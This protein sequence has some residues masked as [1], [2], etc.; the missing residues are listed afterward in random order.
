MLRELLQHVSGSRSAGRNIEEAPGFPD[1]HAFS[2]ACLVSALGPERAAQ[3]EHQI[4]E[5]RRVHDLERKV[6]LR[7][8]ELRATATLQALG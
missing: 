8:R 2:E 5:R 3:V 7:R 6:E 4:A 1:T